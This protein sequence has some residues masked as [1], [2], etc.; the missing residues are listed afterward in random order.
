MPTLSKSTG[1]MTECS[2][3]MPLSAPMQLVDIQEQR[4]HKTLFSVQ[5]TPGHQAHTAMPAKAPANILRPR[6]YS[7]GRAS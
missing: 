4:V 3:T 7:G 1:Y 2:F 6:E 5:E